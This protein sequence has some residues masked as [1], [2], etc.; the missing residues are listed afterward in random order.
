[1]AIVHVTNWN[2]LVDAVNNATED[3]DI[4]IDNDID[5]NTEGNYSQGVPTALVATKTIHVYGDSTTHTKIKNI[6]HRNNF[7]L[8]KGSDVSSVRKWLY[9]HYIDFENVIVEASGSTCAFMGYACGLE[10][11]KVSMTATCLSSAA[12]QSLFGA[13]RSYCDRCG[14][15]I[16]GSNGVR[17]PYILLAGD[18]N[19]MFDNIKLLGTFYDINLGDMRNCYIHGDFKQTHNSGSTFKLNLKACIVNAT[20]DMA[21]LPTCTGSILALINTDNLTLPSGKTLADLSSLLTQCSEVDL[22]NADTLWS[23]YGFPIRG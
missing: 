7:V 20:I 15:T 17:A 11:C 2:D 12:T 16:S 8:F 3:T 13:A 19:C 10:D 1:M 9:F 23:T 21:V 4:Y 18:S 22:R 14:I 5:L 6:Y